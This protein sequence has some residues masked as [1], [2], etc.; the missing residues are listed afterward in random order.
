[1]NQ[2]TKD[3]LRVVH[4]ALKMYLVNHHPRVPALTAA[5]YW[6][7]ESQSTTQACSSLW[8]CSAIADIQAEVEAC[9]TD[10]SLDVHPIEVQVVELINELAQL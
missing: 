2:S 6:L 10:E 9:C 7:K 3:Y 1:M 4:T 8:I 5:S